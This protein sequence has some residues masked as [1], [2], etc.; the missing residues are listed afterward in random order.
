[1][2]RLASLSDTMKGE[3]AFAALPPHL[4][5]QPNY[6][7]AI[8]HSRRVRFLR[9]AIPWGCFAVLLFLVLRGVFSLFVGSDANFGTSGFSIVGRKIVMDKPKLSGF[10]RD[11][12]SYEMTALSAVQDLKH[13]NVMELE[14]L[15]AR[16]QTGSEGIATLSGD[17]GTYDSKEEKLDVR[18]NVRV[19]TEGG[20]DAFLQDAQIEFKGGTVTTDKPTDVKTS[21]GHVK[22][23]RMRVLDNGKR[24][25]FEGNVRSTFANAVPE[26]ATEPDKGTSAP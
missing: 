3:S 2:L 1:M 25:I 23:D 6:Q 20:T 13:P 10:K 9:K 8:R 4:A 21:Q 12:S 15:T 14:K 16:I 7:A 26:G 11:G 22:S 24:L 5:G 19:R 18:G 17:S